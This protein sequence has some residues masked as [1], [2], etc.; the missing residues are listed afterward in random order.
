MKIFCK[1]SGFPQD[2]TDD[3][4]N[5]FDN[6]I[7]Q[8]GVYR[9]FADAARIFSQEPDENTEHLDLLQ[10]VADTCGL[11]LYTVHMLF[12]LFLLPS[13]RNAYKQRGISDEIYYNTMS[14]LQCK[15][16]ECKNVHNVWGTMTLP[17]YRRIAKGKLFKL[18]RLEFEQVVYAKDAV[19]K[20]IVR[21]NDIILNCHIPSCGPLYTEAV[22]ESLKKAYQ[23]YG[24][25]G[26]MP[27]QCNSWLLYPKHYDIYPENG[28]LQKFCDLFDILYA[29]EIN[30]TTCIWRIFGVTTEDFT[31][32]PTDTTLRRNFA[33][34][35]RNG[36]KMGAA[37]GMLLFDGEKIVR[38]E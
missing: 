20:N 34:Y 21:P 26:F 16:I 25:Q 24:Y 23:F 13:V 15:L 27:V 10:S 29:S 9:K 35:L 1:K 14:D 2:A 12:L 30:P 38:P 11:H 19:Y 5:C 8:A 36:G 31:Q 4:C 33:N 32:L 18:G 3:L 28:N 7:T 37:F 17:W 6:L 22:M